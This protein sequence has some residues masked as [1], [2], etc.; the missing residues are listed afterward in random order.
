MFAPNLTCPL[1]QYFVA[2]KKKKDKNLK[3]LL[4]IWL[5]MVPW[6]LRYKS[7]PLNCLFSKSCNLLR[8]INSNPVL[9]EF[10]CQ[11]SHSN[12]TIFYDSILFFGENSLE[13]MPIYFKFNTSLYYHLNFMQLV[14]HSLEALKVTMALGCYQKTLDDN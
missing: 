8:T 2:V 1:S 12:F 7:V 3:Y 4:L 14:L 13:L 5:W 11:V 9:L 10:N 6:Q